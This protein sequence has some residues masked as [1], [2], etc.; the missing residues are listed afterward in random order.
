MDLRTPKFAGKR[1]N[2]GADRRTKAPGVH[3][4]RRFPATARRTPF[5]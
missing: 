1:H 4:V 3:H 2:N 5:N